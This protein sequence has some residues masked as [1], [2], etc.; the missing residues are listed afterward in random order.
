[1]E[2]LKR[3]VRQV[4]DFP[5][6]GDVF[7]DITPLLA[8]PRAFSLAVDTISFR[9]QERRIEAVVGIESRGFLIA[10]PVALRLGVGIVPVRRGAPLPGKARSATYDVRG[11]PQTLVIQEDPLRPGQ[12]VLCVDDLL[13]SGRTMRACVDLVEGLGA[14][15]VACAFVIELE[16]P[17]GRRMLDGREVFSLITYPE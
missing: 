10:A 4:D 12:R 3:Y 13:V 17:G 15:V 1:M 14:Q 2:T 16:R 6:K 5:R 9:F 8:D 7:R 11:T